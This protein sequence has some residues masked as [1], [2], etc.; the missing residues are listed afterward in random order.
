[1]RRASACSAFPVLCGAVSSLLRFHGS[2]GA[3]GLPA[4]GRRP[5]PG[6]LGAAGGRGGVLFSTAGEN[7]RSPRLLSHPLRTQGLSQKARRD[8]GPRNR[9][10]C[11]RRWLLGRSP[12]KFGVL[13][14]KKRELPCSSSAEVSEAARALLKSPSSGPGSW[15]G[16]WCVLVLVW[17]RLFFEVR[18]VTGV[19]CATAFV[20]PG[21]A[22]KL[23]STLSSLQVYRGEVATRLQHESLF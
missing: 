22:S 17:L 10:R 2:P 15:G 4:P 19:G 16:L 5:L 12:T 18:V 23:P 8:R 21:R 20:L 11:R 6:A 13:P 9:K 7:A 14:Q 3:A 1:M